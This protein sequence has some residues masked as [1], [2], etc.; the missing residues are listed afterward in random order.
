MP[1]KRAGAASLGTSKALPWRSVITSAFCGR[2]SG[3][4]LNTL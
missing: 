2:L 4:K 1:A 3:A